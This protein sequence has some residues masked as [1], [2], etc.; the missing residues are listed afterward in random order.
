MK[1][2]NRLVPMLAVLGSWTL[3]PC[4]A[5]AAEPL[6]NFQ[7]S[8]EAER[9]IHIQSIESLDVLNSR[10]IVFK[11]RGG[12]YFVNVLPYSCPGLR[13]HTTIMYRTYLGVLCS[14]DI[15]TLL[16]PMGGGLR[17]TSSCGLGKFYRV[18]EDQVEEMKK[19]SKR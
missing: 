2:S 18:D 14:V 3:G 9:C 16:E 12:D 13:P 15:I 8:D 10:Q 19:A 7:L 4:V 17:P 11:M 1:Y 6:P 5:F